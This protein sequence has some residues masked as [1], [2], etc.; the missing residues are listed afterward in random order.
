MKKAVVLA[1]LLVLTTACFPFTPVPPPA[2][3]EDKAGTA[4]ASLGT[5]VIRTL[6]AQ[7][8]STSLPVL[9]T[10]TSTL[11][12]EVAPSPSATTFLEQTQTPVATGTFEVPTSTDL[13]ATFPT[14]LSTSTL[15]P[16]VLT[17]GTL[18]PA[19]PFSKITLVNRAKTQAYISLQVTT[20]Q[21]G[22][23]ILEYPVQG[24]IELEAPVGQY[25]YVAWVGGRKLVGEFRLHNDEDLEIIL[26]RDR[27]EVK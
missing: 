11:T 4:Q 6:T 21:G 25:L 20:T 7:P 8:T 3:T 13:P 1:A 23:A 27:V 10:E 18:P 19:V 16:A 22:P 26:Y 12:Q 5:A 2:P 24:K 9:S 15:T 14:G 17:W